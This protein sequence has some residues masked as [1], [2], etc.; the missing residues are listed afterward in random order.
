[1]N[2][3]KT[4]VLVYPGFLLKTIAETLKS[5]IMKLKNTKED[6]L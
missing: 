2:N 1:M 4:G 6:L 3:F 5:V